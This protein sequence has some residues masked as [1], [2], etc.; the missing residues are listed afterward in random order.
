MRSIVAT[1]C[2]FFLLLSTL[3]AQETKQFTFSNPYP[4]SECTYQISVAISVT[5]FKSSLASPLD[6]ASTVIGPGDADSLYIEIPE[7]KSIF[8]TTFTVQA[9][10]SGVVH[11]DLGTAFEARANGCLTTKDAHTFWKPIGDNSF[12]IWEAMVTG[13][14]YIRE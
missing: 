6:I 1:V 5:D 9:H 11:K 2:L 14:S 4:F 12:H 7:G 10:G 3:F 13:S 8:S